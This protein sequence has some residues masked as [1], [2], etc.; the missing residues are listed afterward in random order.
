MGNLSGRFRNGWGHFVGE[1]FGEVSNTYR[2]IESRI[3]NSRITMTFAIAKMVETIKSPWRI[4][5]TVIYSV[6]TIDAMVARSL[7]SR[8]IFLLFFRIIAGMGQSQ[9]RRLYLNVAI[10]G[11]QADEWRRIGNIIS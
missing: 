2:T 10:P 9:S 6:V 11:P 8:D 4:L 3:K 7:K 1:A 5:S